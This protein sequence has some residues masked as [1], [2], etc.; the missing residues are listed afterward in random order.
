MAKAS[1]EGTAL[2]LDGHTLTIE[3]VEAVALDFV[4]VQLSEQALEQLRNSR[5]VVDDFLARR[6]VVYGITTGFGKFK[7]VYIPPEATEELQRNFLASHSCGVGE[8]FPQD[9][10]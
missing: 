4:P 2:K 1:R 3:D 9:V 5:R 7:D 6:E 10:V 8:P